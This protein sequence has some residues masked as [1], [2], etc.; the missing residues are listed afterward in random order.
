MSDLRNCTKAGLGFALVAGFSASVALGEGSEVPDGSVAIGALPFADTGDILDNTHEFDAICPWASV[1][2]DVFY[3]YTADGS[4][5]GISVVLCESAYDT[6][7]F[8]LD[9]TFAEVACN[10]DFC[11]SAG[12]GG[13]RS[14]IECFAVTS[15][16][17]YHIAVDGWSGDA[18]VYDLIVDACTPPDAC[19]FGSEDCPAGSLIESEDCPVDVDLGDFV[20]G[21]CN[22]TPT[23]L[24]EMAACGDTVCGT[25]AQGA[26][27]RDTDWYAIS[28]TAAADATMTLAGEL[29]TVFGRIDEGTCTPGAPDCACIG[30][31][32]DP[33]ALPA[34]CVEESVTSAV[35]AGES[36][37][38]VSVNAAGIIAC[39]DEELGNDYVA[40]WT[41]A[42]PTCCTAGDVNEDGDVGFS[43]LVTL[44]GNWG[45]CE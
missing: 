38:F 15:G 18:G 23:P 19:I 7:T 35:V 2:P 3:A 21:G 42:G 11:T 4:A 43:D 37:W 45:P 30:T 33:F 17:T 14:T 31:T 16:M 8:I 41:C 32:V 27:L 25:L 44:L 24:F 12:G 29:D 34:P 22:T 5:D 40:S 6:K 26:T 1:S 20:N 28:A 9:S 36:W 39:G 13:F 10:D